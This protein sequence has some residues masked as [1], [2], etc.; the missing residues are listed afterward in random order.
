MILYCVFLMYHTS[1]HHVYGPMV[2]DREATH[3]EMTQS[4]ALRGM[5][6]PDAKRS[7]VAGP[8]SLKPSSICRTVMAALCH[9][10]LLAVMCQPHPMQLI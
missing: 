4:K 10:Q 1:W 7:Q 6:A 9:S 5:A 2:T 8:V 3:R